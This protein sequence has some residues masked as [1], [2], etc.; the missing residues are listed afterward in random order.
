MDDGRWTMDDDVASF[1]HGLQDCLIR[2]IFCENGIVTTDLDGFVAGFDGIW[3]KVGPGRFARRGGFISVC[4]VRW[5]P[6]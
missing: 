4:L 3:G 1:E 6:V 5:T 2:R